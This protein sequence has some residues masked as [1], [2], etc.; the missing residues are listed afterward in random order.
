MRHLKMI[1]LCLVMVMFLTGCKDI[2]GS[3]ER[4][5]RVAREKTVSLAIANAIYVYDDLTGLCYMVC[6][7]FRTRTITVV[8]YEKV[9]H[10]VI[11]MPRKETIE[12]KR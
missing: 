2:D 12:P 4:K 9:K 5:F 11:Y 3:R 10:L 8:P 6:G 1:V 7:E